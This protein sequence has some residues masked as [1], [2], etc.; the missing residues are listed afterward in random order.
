MATS[1]TPAPRYSK[2]GKMSVPNSLSDEPEEKM[3]SF[4]QT[5]YNASPKRTGKRGDR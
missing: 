4:K 1:K 5:S 3:K 2:S